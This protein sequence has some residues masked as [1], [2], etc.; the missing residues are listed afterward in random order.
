MSLGAFEANV[1]VNYNERTEIARNKKALAGAITE[2]QL[3]GLKEDQLKELKEVDTAALANQLREANEWNTK[4]SDVKTRFD[5]R[6]TD[7]ERA[8]EEIATRE[9]KIKQLEK[10]IK[11][12][13]AEI[14]DATKKNEEA[15]KW[16][17]DNVEK[18]TAEISK[19][20][21]EAGE[22][23]KKAT[24]AQQ[25]LK[26]RKEYLKLVEDEGDMTA[27][28]ELE[29]QA[30]ADAIKSCEGPVKGLTYNDDVLLYNDVA[31]SPDDLS[32]SEIMELGIKLKMSENPDLGVLVIQRG[33]SL[34]KSR[35]ESIM[36]LAAK[37]NWQILMEQVQRG[38][39]KLKI[40]LLA[41]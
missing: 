21:S 14:R 22:T 17:T 16:L 30:I 34:G 26:Q 28:I 33:E 38:Q 25:L 36:E 23:N 19:Q 11:E 1:L 29:R 5:Q 18:D 39:E 6:A 32:T 12:Y 7:I 35:L 27:K 20:L 3:N 24:A 8:N 2:N 40:E 13:N 41:V 9:K 10:E 37:N 4:V 31:V 15:G